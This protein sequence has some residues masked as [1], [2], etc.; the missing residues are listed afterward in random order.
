[1][2]EAR[3]ATEKKFENKIR[4]HEK[5]LQIERIIFGD[6]RNKLFKNGKLILFE[7]IISL[8]KVIEYFDQK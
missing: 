8:E 1:M 5:Q 4:G 3:F 7:T 2:N 6:D